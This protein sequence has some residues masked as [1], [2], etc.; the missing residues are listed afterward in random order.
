MQGYSFNTKTGK[1][2][3]VKVMRECYSLTAPHP[4]NGQM[5][6]WLCDTKE[7]AIELQDT[8]NK[9]YELPRKTRT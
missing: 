4:A 6:T 1:L 2:E 5:H 3:F 8:L 7:Q 9:I